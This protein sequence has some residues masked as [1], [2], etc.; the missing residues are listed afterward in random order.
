[1]R[2]L[3]SGKEEISKEEEEETNQLKLKKKNNKIKNND[4][5]KKIEQILCGVNIHLIVLKK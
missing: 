2:G 5:S 3:I 1:M 4:L